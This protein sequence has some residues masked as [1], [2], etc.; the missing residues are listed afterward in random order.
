VFRYKGQQTS[1][2]SV[3]QDLSVKAV[4]T[5]RI[6]QRGDQL[7]IYV[8]LENAADNSHIWGEQYNRHVSDILAIQDEISRIVTEKLSVRINE[9]D[10]RRLAKRATDDVQAYQLYLRGQWFLNQLTSDGKRQALACF[11]QAIAIDPNYGL[12]YSGLADIYVLSIGSPEETYLKA[13]AAAKKAL[14]LD[15]TLGEAH[16]TLGFIKSHYERDWAGAEAE[17][18]R[19]IELKPN[20]ATAHHYYADQLAAL[21]EFDRAFPIL[22]RAAELDPLAPIIN[23]DIGAFFFFAREYDKSIEHLRKTTQQFPDFWPGHYYLAWAYTQKKMYSDA[24][25]EY[26]Q[27]LTLSKGHSMV[28]AMTGYTYGMSGRKTE[29]LKI[30]KQLQA[31]N[32]DQYVPPLR[33]AVVY[34]GLGN[35]D[36]AFEWLNTACDKR[37]LLVIYMKVLPFFDAL[38]NDRRFPVLL[39]RLNLA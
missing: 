7:S 3:G 16:T 31:K 30:L 27:A 19:A 10:R 17:Y 23:A 8:G 12:A 21:G 2:Q 26:Q 13:E 4:L 11:E 22:Q 35:K 14:Q 38:R 18:K 37:D 24:L 29:A 36:K 5:G 20:Y 34:T 15:P 6:V 28:L 1:A 33:F 25:S 32:P 39:K 9:D